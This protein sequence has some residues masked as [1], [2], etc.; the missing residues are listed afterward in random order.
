MIL[1]TFFTIFFT[2]FI[3]FL[4]IFYYSYSYNKQEKYIKLNNLVIS[5]KSLNISFS[6]GYNENNTQL[7]NRAFLFHKNTN[8]MDFIYAK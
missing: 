7:Q 5:T 1:K 8:H 6:N 4:F 2:I 3:S